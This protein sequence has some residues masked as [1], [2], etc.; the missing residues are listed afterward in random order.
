MKLN[1]YLKNN[2]LTNGMFAETLGISAEA[3]RRYRRGIRI[4]SADMMLRIVEVTGGEV[5]PN[6]FYSLPY[7]EREAA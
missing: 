5:T 2:C 7:E 6:D 1:E 3:V 4:P